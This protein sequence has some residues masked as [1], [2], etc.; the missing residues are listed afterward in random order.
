VKCIDFWGEGDQIRAA[1]RVAPTIL[2]IGL[3]SVYIAVATL[4]IPAECVKFTLAFFLLFVR[5]YG[6]MNVHE[7]LK[8]QALRRIC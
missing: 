3:Q 4:L 8:I 6:I 5:K 1:A 2:G 7:G